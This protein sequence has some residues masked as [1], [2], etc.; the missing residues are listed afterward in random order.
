M[1]ARRF[2]HQPVA[3]RGRSARYIQV[4]VPLPRSG[5]RGRTDHDVVVAGQGV[6]IER[7]RVDKQHL[8]AR[9]DRDREVLHAVGPG[10][11]RGVAGNNGDV[12]VAVG[13]EDQD[14]RAA[15]NAGLLDV[16]EADPLVR[17]VDEGALVVLRAGLEHQRTRSNDVQQVARG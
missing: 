3:G 16:V 15:G 9:I 6:D 13:S 17:A 1:G 8:R 10:V 11:S 5:G 12:V 14:G 4:D 7:R 2:Q